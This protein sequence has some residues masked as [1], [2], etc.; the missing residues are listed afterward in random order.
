LKPWSGLVSV[1]SYLPILAI[2]VGFLEIIAAKPSSQA[3]RVGAVEKGHWRWTTSCVG[4]K[5]PCCWW[6]TEVLDPDIP[7]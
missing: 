3:M 2:K 7:G 6:G 4:S 5:P 1:G